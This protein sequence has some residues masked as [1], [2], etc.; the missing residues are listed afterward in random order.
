MWLNDCTSLNSGTS[1]AIYFVL[2]NVLPLLLALVENSGDVG[3]CSLCPSILGGGF[4]LLKI[5]YHLIS[6]GLGTP[7]VVQ[8]TLFG[9][10]SVFLRAQG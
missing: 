9:H 3:A 7:L 1:C 6:V 8:R 10:T 5:R 2:T 4:I